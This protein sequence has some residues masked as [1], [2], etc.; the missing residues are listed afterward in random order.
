MFFLLAIFFV[1]S[2][3]DILL[4]FSRDEIYCQI[5]KQLSRNQNKESSKKGWILLSLC[6][7]CFAPTEKVRFHAMNIY[8]NYLLFLLLIFKR[9]H[10]LDI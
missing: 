4:Y 5:S 1:Y 3:V 9:S 7:G 10:L 6:L 8:Y 2:F